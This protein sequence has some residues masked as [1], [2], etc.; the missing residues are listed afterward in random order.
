MAH[1]ESGAC[2]GLVAQSAPA[3]GFFRASQTADRLAAPCRL[4]AT[5]GCYAPWSEF[6][7]VVGSSVRSSKDIGLSEGKP[8]DARQIGI[9][10]DELDAD[11]DD[12]DEDDDADAYDVDTNDADEDAD[13][14]D[15]TDDE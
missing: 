10:D 2:G 13:A 7:P 14:D 4:S 8:R 12:D 3:A 15:D 11:W 9:D 5:A 6:V 1:E